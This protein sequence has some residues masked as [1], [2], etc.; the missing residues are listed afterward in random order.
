MV[1]GTSRGGKEPEPSVAGLA[2][3]DDAPVVE[4][5]FVAPRALEI[6]QATGAQ[7]AGLAKAGEAVFE[8]ASRERRI[9]ED[10]VPGRGLVGL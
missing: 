6:D 9:E 1:A 10:D 5:R 3:F 8:Q 4:V 7:G 2:L